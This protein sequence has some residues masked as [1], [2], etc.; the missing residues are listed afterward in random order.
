MRSHEIL[1]PDESQFI[2]RRIARGV[3]LLDD[4]MPNWRSK[5][6]RKKF[7]IAE[8]HDCILGQLYGHFTRGMSKLNMAL[9]QAVDYGFGII[10]AGTWEKNVSY[11]EN[12]QAAWVAELDK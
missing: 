8:G 5:I 7:L 1:N 12:L 11:V 10:V 3:K 9:S 6:N 2:K 4:K